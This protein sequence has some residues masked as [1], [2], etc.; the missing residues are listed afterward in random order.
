MALDRAKVVP[1]LHPLDSVTYELTGDARKS[2]GRCQQAGCAM[3]KIRQQQQ[4]FFAQGW[5]DNGWA[6]LALPLLIGP[7]P[8]PHTRVAALPSHTTAHTIA[9]KSKIH[10]VGRA[11]MHVLMDISMVSTCVGGVVFFL[12]TVSC[13]RSRTLSGSV[14]VKVLSIGVAFLLAASG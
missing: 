12:S 10:A 5:A 7:N 6:R 14:F 8:N 3:M 13:N 4:F 2:H 9:T 1:K 11:L